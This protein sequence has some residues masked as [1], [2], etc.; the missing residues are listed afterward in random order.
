MKVTQV[1]QILNTVI[2]EVLGQQALGE[3]GQPISDWVVSEDLSNV[4]SVG[5]SFD[6]MLAQNNAYDKYIGKLI[7]HIGRVIF[8]DRVY[9]GQAP[10]VLLDGWE[11]GSILEKIDCGLPESQWN[12]SWELTD[13]TTYDQ[14]VFKAPKDVQVQFFNDMVTFEVDMSFTN[15]QIRQSFSSAQQLNG[16]FSMIESRI[17]M[18]RTMDYDN[19]IMRTIN[20]F[21]AA[22]LET[23]FDDTSVLTGKTGPRAVNLLH[24]YKTNVS[25]ADKTLTPENCLKNTEFL[26]FASYQ[27]MLWSDR[28]VKASTMFNIGKRVRFTPKNLQHIVLLSEFERAADVYLQS[29]TFHN[30]LTKLPKAESVTFW[31]G[32]G[33]DFSFANTSEI[34]VVI[35]D[36]NSPNGNGTVEVAVSGILGVMFDRDALGVNNKE[37]RITSHY[38]AKAEFTNN[39]YKS[40]ARFFNDYKENF[41]VFFV[42]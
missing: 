5:K 1:S 12:M 22:T 40:D 7:N 42:A 38:N 15:L 13:G 8:V 27:L 14:D 41:I 31:Q 33:E 26:K 6:N 11:Y 21:T 25:G 20:H 17:Q 4:V 19:L 32:S 39:F 23:S 24:L 16:F 36:P 35:R 29:S 30:E 10:S 3:D 37:N 2:R 18:R 34:H 28:L 9:E